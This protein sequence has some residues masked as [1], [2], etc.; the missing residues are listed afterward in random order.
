MTTHR[1]LP[2]LI[3]LALL[4]AGCAVVAPAPHANLYRLTPLS[5]EQPGTAQKFRILVER[6]QS[7]ASLDT[8]RVA[9]SRGAIDFDYFAD[10]EWVDSAPSMVHRLLIESLDDGEAVIAADAAGSGMA[11]DR[12]LKTDLRAFQAEYEGTGGAPTAHVRINAKLLAPKTL[13]ILTSK[14]FDARV[15]AEANSQKAIIEAFDAA[16]KRVITD[17]RAFAT[18]ET[19]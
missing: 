8:Q 13:E 6:P 16:L 17:I 15:P 7:S 14:T 4:A 9:L 19:P 5:M 18:A 3:A 12:T 2:V 1:T 11:L 10:V